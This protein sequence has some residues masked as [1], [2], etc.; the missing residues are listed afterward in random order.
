M[1]L[2]RLSKVRV[3]GR[4]RKELV[5]PLGTERTGSEDV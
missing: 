5:D 2:T 3:R 1:Y 4:L